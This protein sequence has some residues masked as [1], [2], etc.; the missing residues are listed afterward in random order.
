MH[1]ANSRTRLTIEYRDKYGAWGSNPNS[2]QRG[3]FGRDKRGGRD[4]GGFGNR[5]RTENDSGN[6]RDGPRNPRPSNN[7]VDRRGGDNF[8]DRNRGGFARREPSPPRE[9]KRLNLKKKEGDEPVN[10]NQPLNPPPVKQPASPAVNTPSKPKSDPFGGAKAVDQN[11]ILEAERRAEEKLRNMSLKSQD[12]KSFDEDNRDRRESTRD[13]NPRDQPRNNRDSR[14][15]RPENRDNDR[16]RYDDRQNSYDRDDYRGGQGRY[17]SY[18]SRDN[19]DRRGSEA[20]E[21]A[22]KERRKLNLRRG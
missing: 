8:G 18:D 15:Y 10:N 21:E 11:K 13:M 9:R 2:I 1:T 14:D 12:S 22:P 7:F 6:W 20:R 4:R 17:N 3:G 5:D 19:F 16:R